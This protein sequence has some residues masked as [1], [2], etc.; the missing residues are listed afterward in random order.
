MKTKLHYLVGAS[1][2]ASGAF[3]LNAQT[4]VTDIYLVNPSFEY[5]DEGV[6]ANPGI[7]TILASANFP[8]WKAPAISGQYANIEIVD[9]S[10]SSSG[11]GKQVTPSS[12]DFYFFNRMGW[13]D[14]SGILSQTTAVALPVGRYHI[15]FDYKAASSKA[16][17]S[18]TSLGV[19][20]KQGEAVIATMEKTAIGTNSGDASYFTNSNWKTLG[21]WFDVE[22]EGVV[23]IN[24]NEALGG[25]EGRA[26][27]CLDNFRLHKWDTDQK[28]N[29]ANASPT[30]PLDVSHFVVNRFFDNDVNGWEAISGYKNKTRAKNQQGDFSGYFYEHWNGTGV[31]GKLNQ[32]IVGLPAGKYEVKMAAFTSNKDVNSGLYVYANGNKVEVSSDVPSF[33]TVQTMILDGE[34]LEIGLENSN[35]TN[36]W[37]GL[38]N[39]SLSYL[40]F[41]NSEALTTA[42]EALNNAID[43]A[44]AVYD[45]S[46]DGAAELLAAIANADSFNNSTDIKAINNAVVELNNAVKLFIVLSTNIATDFIVNPSFESG[47]TGWENNGFVTT[48]SGNFNPYKDGATFIEAWVPNNNALPNK[49]MSQTIIDVPNGYYILT[50]AAHAELQINNAPEIIGASLYINNAEVSVSVRDYYS[51]STTVTDGKMEI[52]YKTVG[53]NANWAAFDN[54]TLKYYTS[55]AAMYKGE[56]NAAVADAN[57]ALANEDYKNILGSER[58]ELLVLASQNMPETAEDVN[59]VILQIKELTRIFISAKPSYDALVN[60]IAEAATYTN[61]NYPYASTVKFDAI[62]S[63]ITSLPENPANATAAL[64][65][66][67][68][69]WTL[70]RLFVESNAVAEGVTGAQD[71]T[72]FVINNDA[73]GDMAAWEQNHKDGATIKILDGESFTDGG[74]NANYK[75]FDG[76]NWGAKAWTVDFSQNVTLPKGKYILTVTGRASDALNSFKLMANDAIVDI[77][78]INATVGTG[79]FDRGW[80]DAAVEFVVENQSDVNVKV[81]AETTAQYQWLSF[82]RF[83][84]TR[85]GDYV[86]TYIT[87]IEKEESLFP[88]NVYGVDGKLIR[89]DATSL[90]GLTKGFYIV[91]GKK[92]VIE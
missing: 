71:Y 60:A 42:L 20:I 44:N 58:S 63:F 70:I 27:I 82:T 66:S 41:D 92:V 90:E 73:L 74:G 11:F 15:S 4:D 89:K 29:Y 51:V 38:D 13:A 19:E 59:N 48:T 46:K 79:T 55:E 39:V 17:P 52:G 87:E 21:F 43:K 80:N 86:P 88:C 28:V 76:G 77:P 75:Y 3:S 84:L 54:F 62:D 69:L 78:C 53:T 83:R 9:N 31:V 7:N 1:F 34:T 36:G 57:L 49:K 56:F 72:A 32:K 65:S 30:S 22:Q 2:L 14:A 35:T 23:T 81:Y 12:G 26:D 33:Y 67:K 68:D 10:N 24:I 64:D 61:D 45:I 85:L 6:V 40:G 16:E 47:I 50:A 18:K 37:I 91:G 5:I 25:S 8:G